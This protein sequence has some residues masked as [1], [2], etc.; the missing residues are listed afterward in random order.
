M[1]E[2]DIQKVILDYLRYKKIFCWKVNNA[3]IYKKKTGAYI[4]TG[5][6]G[7]SDIIGLLPNGLFLAIEVKRP[8]KEPLDNQKE[9]LENIRKNNGVGLVAYSVDDVIE[10][11]ENYKNAFKQSPN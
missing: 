2:Q 8:G 4:P 11:L 10:F 5:L 1:L 6:L 3:G 9:F 7:V